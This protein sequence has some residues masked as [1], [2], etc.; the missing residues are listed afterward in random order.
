MRLISTRPEVF[1]EKVVFKDFAIYTWK[2]LKACNFIKKKLQH[3]SFPMNI[4]KLLRTAFLMGQLR[5]LL[6]EIASFPKKC[7]WD[8]NDINAFSQ[9]RKMTSRFDLLTRKFYRNSSFKLLTRR[10]NI[11]FSTFKLLT[12]SW[13]IKKFTSSY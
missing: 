3:R 4:A 1:C 9:L 5:W 6:L 13:K 2:R 7:S 10:F 8:C 12:R 11:Y